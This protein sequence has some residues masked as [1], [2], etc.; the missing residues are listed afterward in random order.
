[1]PTGAPKTA[2]KYA[3]PSPRN[4]NQLPLGNHPGNTGG[5]KGRSGRKPNTFLTKCLAASEDPAL[6]HAASK[7]HPLGLLD[8]AAGYA[9]GKPKQAHEITGDVTIHVEYD[10]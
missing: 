8:L 7:K 3:K 10:E 5:K 9:H 2:T 1:M 4:G 6:W